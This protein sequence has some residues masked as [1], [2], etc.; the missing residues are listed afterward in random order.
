MQS[1]ALGA[2]QSRILLRTRLDGRPAGARSACASPAPSR[3][4]GP[5]LPAAGPGAAG[6]VSGTRPASGPTH[7]RAARRVDLRARRSELRSRAVYRD[8]SAFALP[9]RAHAGTPDF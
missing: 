7:G 4:G 1:L 8:V 9:V 2:R 6:V 5:G 3:P